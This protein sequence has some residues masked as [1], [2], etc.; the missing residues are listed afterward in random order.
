MNLPYLK[1]HPIHVFRA[2]A[3][4]LGALSHWFSRAMGKRN[5]NHLSMHLCR[6]IERW[7]KGMRGR[8]RELRLIFFACSL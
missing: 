4:A 2:T 8:L 7:G 1:P 5:L 6:C 3:A